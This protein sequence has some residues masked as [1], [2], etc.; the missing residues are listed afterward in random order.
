MAKDKSEALRAGNR[1]DRRGR[2]SLYSPLLG[3]GFEVL[4]PLT[5]QACAVYPP[6]AMIDATLGC[7]FGTI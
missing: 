3:A 4:Q 2:A 6:L 5:I 1:R 7:H